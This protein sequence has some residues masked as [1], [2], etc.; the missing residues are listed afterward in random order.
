MLFGAFHY[1][2]PRV[3][4]QDKKGHYEHMLSFEARVKQ[5]PER[6]SLTGQGRL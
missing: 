2:V 3:K 5:V 4:S 6:Q 1:R